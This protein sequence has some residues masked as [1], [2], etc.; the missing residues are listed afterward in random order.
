LK[1]TLCN[2]RNPVRI[3]SFECTQKTCNSAFPYK[4]K[5][6]MVL[7]QHLYLGCCSMCCFLY[8]YPCVFYKVNPNAN[9]TTREWTSNV[10]LVHS[11]P[12]VS[13]KGFPKVNDTTYQPIFGMS[14]LKIIIGMRC[15]IKRN[16]KQGKVPNKGL[17]PSRPRARTGC[18]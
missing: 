8:L 3:R 9:D 6:N 4:E 11:W 15:Q 13:C 12:H 18:W 5:T 2:C 10:E 7:T 17:N 14:S 16:K 1:C